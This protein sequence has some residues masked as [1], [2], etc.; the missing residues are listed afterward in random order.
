MEPRVASAPPQTELNRLFY[1]HVMVARVTDDFSFNR[2]DFHG[3]WYDLRFVVGLLDGR[4][5]I[6][7]L[8]LV[9]AQ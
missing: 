6:S 5:I 4:T 8:A 1:I 9:A 7:T 2:F 3:S